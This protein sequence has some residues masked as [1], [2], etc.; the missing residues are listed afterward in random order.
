MPDFQVTTFCVIDLWT[1]GQRMATEVELP[2]TKEFARR[3]LLQHET[4]MATLHKRKVYVEH[5]LTAAID[6]VLKLFTRCKT[7]ASVPALS[8]VVTRGSRA[9]SIR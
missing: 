7:R 4:F 8:S 3:L 9:F 2:H 6:E 1:L 5:A